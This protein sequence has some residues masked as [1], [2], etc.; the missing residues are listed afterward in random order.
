MQRLPIELPIEERSS[1]HRCWRAR[2]PRSWP[3]SSARDGVTRFSVGDV[4][5]GIEVCHHLPVRGAVRLQFRGAILRLAGQIDD[6]LFRFVDPALERGDLLRGTSPDSRQVCSPRSG[7]PP[8][9]PWPTASSTPSPKQLPA[10]RA[11][12]HLTPVPRATR[13]ELAI[14][15]EGSQAGASQGVSAAGCLGSRW[16]DCQTTRRPAANSIGGR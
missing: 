13:P 14:N 12:P 7:T 9:A 2:C 15:V 1:R 3:S 16:R 4:T 11:Q 8:T 5:H 10:F 6:L